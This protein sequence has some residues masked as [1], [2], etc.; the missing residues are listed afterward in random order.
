[1]C[2]LG[3]AGVVT[4]LNGNR[5]AAV[6][7]SIPADQR[8][9]E[10]STAVDQQFALLRQCIS[11][12]GWTFDA[13]A[14]EMR[15]DKGYLWKLLHREKTEWKPEHTVALPN[16]VEALF[17]QRLSESFGAIVVAPVSKEQALKNL[18]SGICGVFGPQLPAKAG[19]PLKADL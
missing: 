18:V 1:M 15:I 17:Y 6:R 14:V 9:V 16:D 11:D 2:A 5:S 12:C 19:K 8:S 7:H 10:R 3:G 4:R 13:L